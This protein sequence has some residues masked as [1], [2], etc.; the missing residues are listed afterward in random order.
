VFLAVNVPACAVLRVFHAHRLPPG[1]L[2]VAFH[3]VL[4]VGDVLLLVFQTVF[5]APGQLA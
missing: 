5:F 2:A 3:A 1:D 4:H